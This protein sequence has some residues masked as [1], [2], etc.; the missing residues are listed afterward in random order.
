MNGS[1]VRCHRFVGVSV[2]NTMNRKK[3]LFVIP[4]LAGGGA[5]RVFVHLMNNLNRQRFD[6]VLAVL[7]RGGPYFNDLKKDIDVID[8]NVEFKKSLFRVVRCIKTVQPD[9]VLSTLCFLNIVVGFSRL[10]VWSRNV[11]FIARESNTPSQQKKML[12]TSFILDWLYMVSYRLFDRV[13]C[14]SNDMHADVASLFKVPAS[15]L[16]TINNPVNVQH[17][18]AMADSTDIVFDKNVVNLLA[19]GRL[20]PQKGFDLL[21]ESFGASSRQDVHLHIVGSGAEEGELKNQSHALGLADHV[22]FHGFLS[23]PYSLMM[24]ADAF[25]LSSRYEGFPNVLVEALAL[26]CPVVAFQCPGGVNEIVRQ[27]QNGILVEPQDIVGLTAAIDAGDYLMMNRDEIAT[28]A[29][30][31]FDLDKIVSRY[32]ALFV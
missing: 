6:V 8:L 27:G 2:G 21:L 20:S 26:G 23:N 15:K 7:K 22:T 30:A 14:Q 9:V 13:V 4:S 24:Q 12:K 32:E 17:L 3:I 28:D 10:F 18:V 1:L 25:V 19:V 5:E 16:I 29:R 11:R 31:R